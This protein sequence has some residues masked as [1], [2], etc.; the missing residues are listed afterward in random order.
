ML[1][2]SRFCSSDIVSTARVNGIVMTLIYFFLLAALSTLLFVLV[3]QRK[4][5][6]KA[7]LAAKRAKARASQIDSG[8]EQLAIAE[9]LSAQTAPI[10]LPEPPARLKTFK[11]LPEESI[12]ES[13]NARL[14]SE[15]RNLRKPPTSVNEMLSPGFIEDATPQ[16]LSDLILG[17]PQL[18]AKVLVEVNS[19]LYGLQQQIDSVQRA[20]FFL[21]INSIRQIALRYSLQESTSHTSGA[22]NALYSR[23]WNT[24]LLASEL[25]VLLLKKLGHTSTAS[26][27]TRT[28]LSFIGE[29]PILNMMTE[30]DA[31][32]CWTLALL[33]RVSMQQRVLGLNA[34][35][36]G[37]RCLQEWG[38][39]QGIIIGID[40]LHRVLIRP[41]LPDEDESHVQT[42]VAYICCRLIE[43][44]MFTRRDHVERL[45]LSALTADEY[46]HARNSL[47]ETT[48]S[49]I[50]AAF[51]T[52]E[53]RQLFQRA[54][55]A[56]NA[57][58]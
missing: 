2:V 56:A 18:V 57:I 40:R 11:W 51:A 41:A 15:V 49:R 16:Q 4:T 10:T 38:V 1:N 55:N 53:I 30:K 14:N 5:A 13:L 35:I 46:F 42:V 54:L 34:D 29:F 23:I 44:L 8:A 7:A 39:P 25:C 31:L 47:T 27:S 50:D 12:D 36:A 52:K 19:P 32:D 24:G 17:E 22:L 9:K 43:D 6:E 48:S 45:A 26:A 28:V 37:R 3:S 20:I 58:G 21:G 33:D